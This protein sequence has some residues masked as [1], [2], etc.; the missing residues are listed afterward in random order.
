M[1]A[2]RLENVVLTPICDTPPPPVFWVLMSKRVVRRNQQLLQRHCVDSC[3]PLRRWIH[4]ETLPR[5][6]GPYP[7]SSR[8]RWPLCAQVRMES[9]PAFHK[10]NSEKFGQLQQEIRTL[11]ALDHPNIVKYFGMGHGC[12]F[13]P[14]RNDCGAR[15]RQ[16]TMHRL[17]GTDRRANSFFIFLDYIA[18]L[19]SLGSGFGVR[20]VC[21]CV[22][23][24]PARFQHALRI[25]TGLSRRPPSRA[26]RREALCL[27]FGR[28]GH[29]QATAFLLLSIVL[30]IF[31][32]LHF[33][34]FWPFWPFSG[35]FVCFLCLLSLWTLGG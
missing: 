21:E 20:H 6:R 7:V 25:R 24:F 28:L 22:F 35:G 5:R 1:R 17:P 19:H 2:Q 9:D 8:C 33:Y 10:V 15:S 14:R 3:H 4:G 31:G 34:Y 30:A 12:C 29:F 27:I 32:Q 13:R 16:S 18:G 23:L 11:Q 26:G